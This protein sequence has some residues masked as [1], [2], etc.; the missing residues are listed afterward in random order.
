MTARAVRCSARTYPLS[1]PCV[2]FIFYYFGIQRSPLVFFQGID[3]EMQGYYL[4]F[5]LIYFLRQYKGTTVHY[6]FSTFF[7]YTRVLPCIVSSLFGTQGYYLVF[8]MSILNS[9]LLKISEKI[10]NLSKYPP[11]IFRFSD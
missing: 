8:N 3:K 10:Q 9:S 6:M 1:P 4:M 7:R 5:F 11:E 2:F